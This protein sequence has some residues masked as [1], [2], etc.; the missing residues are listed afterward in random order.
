MEPHRSV[1][2]CVAFITLARPPP[3]LPERVIMKYRAILKTDLF[4]RGRRIA[5]ARRNSGASC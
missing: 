4:I 2:Y 1:I 5:N 3:G